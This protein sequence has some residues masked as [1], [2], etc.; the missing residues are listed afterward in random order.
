MTNRCQKPNESAFKWKMRPRNPFERKR[1]SW[2]IK[3]QTCVRSYPAPRQI[4]ISSAEKNI[5]NGRSA[6][7][8]VSHRPTQPSKL[9]STRRS[10][11]SLHKPSQLRPRK[12]RLRFPQPPR[13]P[14]PLRLAVPDRNQTIRPI[15]KPQSRILEILGLKIQNHNIQIRLPE[16]HNAIRF[17]NHVLTGFHNLANHL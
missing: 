11:P 3:Y 12:S 17:N 2:R 9:S 6:L 13:N 16:L 8:M 7:W 1:S 10:Q 14:A 15:Q 5:S 4:G